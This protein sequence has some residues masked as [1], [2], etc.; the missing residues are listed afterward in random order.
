MSLKTL[1]AVHLICC[2]VPLDMDRAISEAKM[3]LFLDI[4]TISG[5]GGLEL[6]SWWKRK[7]TSTDRPIDCHLS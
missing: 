5:C 6:L 4:A 3:V 1:L 2:T 7:K